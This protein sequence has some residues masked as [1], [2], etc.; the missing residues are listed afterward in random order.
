[1]KT[2]LSKFLFVTVVTIVSLS[3]F[4]TSYA[5]ENTKSI[6]L[7]IINTDTT[8]LDQQIYL[9]ES[10]IVT[11]SNNT[12]STFSGFKAICALQQSLE[13]NQID[14]FKVT[15]WDWGFSLDA[16]NDIE[17]TSDWSQSWIL[18]NNNNDANVGIADLILED[19]DTL[20]LIYDSW[21]QNILD[22]YSST[23]YMYANE[24]IN[25]ESLIWNTDSFVTNTTAITFYINGESVE[26]NNGIF[27][28]TPE[29]TGTYEFYVDSTNALASKKINIS[30]IEPEILAT[31]TI[32]LEIQTFDQELY[33][34]D[35][36]VTACPNEENNTENTFNIWCAIEQLSE[37]QGWS[38]YST[39]GD[40]GVTYDINDYKGND[41]SDGMWWGWYSDLIP[42]ESGVNV[43]ILNVDKEKENILLVYGIE[44][45]KLVINNT[46]PTVSSTIEVEYQKFDWGVY[47]WIPNASSTFIINNEEIFD[48]DGIYELNITT[49][50]P[51]TIYA[52]KNGFI[53]SETITITPTGQNKENSTTTTTDTSTE[54]PT[55]GGSSSN[56]EINQNIPLTQ[57]EISIA[58]NKILNYLKNEQSADGKISD[59]NTTDWIIMSFGANEQYAKDIKKG[60]FS[61]IDYAQKQEITNTTDNN[62]C[63]GFARHSLALLAS[64]SD[65][66]EKINHLNDEMQSDKCYSPTNSSFGEEYGSGTN[67]DVFA[68][69]ALLGSDTNTS[70]QIIID[71]INNIKNSQNQTSG[72]FSIGW[73]E[74]PD[75]TGVSISALKYA[76]KKGVPVN[77]TIYNSAENYLKNTQLADG[78]WGFDNSDILTTSWVMMGINALQQTQ[79][80]WFNANH[81][82]PW[83]L[84]A[85]NLT[86]DGSYNTTWEPISVDWFGLKHAVPS[87]L[88]K[89]WP[90][91]L[92]PIIQPTNNV[93][94]G[95]IE[96]NTTSTKTSTEEIVTSTPEII[97]DI[98]TSTQKQKIEILPIILELPVENIQTTNTPIAETK[99]TKQSLIAKNNLEQVLGEKTETTPK[100]KIIEEEKQNIQTNETLEKTNEK[101]ETPL[102]TNKK[103][104]LALGAGTLLY[105]LY[106]LFKMFV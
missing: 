81:K 9:P 80:D 39:W 37:Q 36:T 78:G 22:I 100:D 55:S 30:V 95:S 41:F 43:Y 92:D 106:L 96:T 70:E 23:T 59:P 67:D 51:Y 2:V 44:P 64:G 56:N 14:S 31:T 84:L 12:T 21:P 62:I 5:T 98:A 85:N 40:F 65:I 61:L 102:P 25:I 75:A 104:A 60:I 76:Q 57:S 42:G 63:A 29:N 4:N 72:G 73:G 99:L 45:S 11:N 19:N 50:T 1:M 24:S 6:N 66:S 35:F 58:V 68:L 47:S 15:D 74:T 8:I 33:N 52:Q 79:T 89:T 101:Q 77:E 18:K 86:N 87:L 28:F 20:T 69:L 93:G 103:V 82:N 88:G 53:T 10:C 13:N 26:T 105:G 3:A 71:L 17:N 90:I 16:I 34:D 27:T 7:K 83:Q 38:L 91:I 32:H 48:E 46:N 94:G 54:N 49:T 97:D